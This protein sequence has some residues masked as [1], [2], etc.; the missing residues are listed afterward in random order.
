MNKTNTF[1][2]G[3]KNKEHMNN[4]GKEFLTQN[5][6]SHNTRSKSV[7]LIVL[8][9]INLTLAQLLVLLWHHFIVHVLICTTLAVST[10]HTILTQSKL[11]LAVQSLRNQRTEWTCDACM[12]L[13]HVNTC[14]LKRQE[15]IQSRKLCVLRSVKK[16]TN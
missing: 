3:K 7:Q 10:D 1:K 8:V 11:W 2:S 15:L 14:R 9:L 6:D 12:C 16:C 5:N 13:F 4:E